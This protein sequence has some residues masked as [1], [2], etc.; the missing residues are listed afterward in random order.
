VKDSVSGFC[1]FNPFRNSASVPDLDLE[2]DSK[3]DMYP[4]TR[5]EFD[6]SA[7][8]QPLLGEEVYAT[9]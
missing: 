9:I 5:I 7:D 6:F 1:C 3:Y 8:G 2:G 4:P